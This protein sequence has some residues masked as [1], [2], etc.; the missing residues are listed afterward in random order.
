MEEFALDTIPSAH[1][2]AAFAALGEPVAPEEVSNRLSANL[3]AQLCEKDDE[4]VE[5]AVERAEIYIGALLRYKGE[6]LNLDDAVVREL[7]LMQTIYELHL[8]LG[9]E[10]AGREYR[11]QLKHTFA[12]VYGA[13]PEGDSPIPAM[14][15]GA[16]AKPKRRAK[17]WTR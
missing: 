17:R 16:L 5:R 14:P 10:E 11:L 2:D 6:S 1:R 15:S 12:A 7:V 4:T 3:Y 9:H 13:L 8:A